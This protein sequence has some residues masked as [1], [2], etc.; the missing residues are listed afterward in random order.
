MYYN[1]DVSIGTCVFYIPIGQEF[2][3][4]TMV[5]QHIGMA[6]IILKRILTIPTRKSIILDYR[7]LKMKDVTSPLFIHA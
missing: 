1:D 7:A 6:Y 5:K 2:P 3:H 4:G